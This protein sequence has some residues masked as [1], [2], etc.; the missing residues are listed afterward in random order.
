MATKPTSLPEWASGPAAEIQD[1][2]AG[3]RAIGWI[4]EKPPHEWF[5]W[6]LNL[7]YQ[8]CSW[9]NN[10]TKPVDHRYVSVTDSNTV[11]NTGTDTDFNKTYTIPANT[12]EI[13]NTIRVRGVVAVAIAASTELIVKIHLG[14][15]SASLA[16]IGAT[17]HPGFV[18][19]DASFTIRTLGSGNSSQVLS[20]L[21]IYSGDT[22]NPIM[23]SGCT[24]VSTGSTIIDQI[25]KASFQFTVGNAGN[26][27]ILKQLVVDL[28]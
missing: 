27:A 7:I 25:V 9:L 8:W 5:N 24:V 3:K 18:V 21:G 23:A 12:M 20:T 13:G 17:T 1:P 10:F 4:A 16:F 28:S 19:F 2:G 22:T 26:T 14:S 15:Y 11:A 6:L